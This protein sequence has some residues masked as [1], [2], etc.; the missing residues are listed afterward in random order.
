[1]TDTLKRYCNTT[2]SNTNTNVNIVSA[3]TSGAVIRNIHFCNTTGS[4]ITVNVSIGSSAATTYSASTALYTAFSIPANGIHVAN[5]NVV[6]NA[7]ERICA[8]ASASGV[9]ATISGVDL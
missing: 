1:M 2:L 9:V 5:V 4:A 7:S 8:F 3:G 6:L